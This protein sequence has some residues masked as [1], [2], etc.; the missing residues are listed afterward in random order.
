MHVIARR[1]LVAFWQSHPDSKRQLELWYHDACGADW[2][3]S[4]EVKARYATASVI[5]RER[6]VFNV[7]GNKYRL[8]ARIN[9]AS[10]TLFIRHVGTH[11]QYNRIDAETV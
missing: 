1:T 4:A 2:Q 3:N 7:C 9:Y 8:I 5:N 6:I 10:Q 11:E